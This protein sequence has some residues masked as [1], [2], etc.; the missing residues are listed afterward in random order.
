[1]KVIDLLK[2]ID[3]GE[4]VPLKIKV[5]GDIYKFD[6]LEYFYARGNGD[7]LL[8]LS[9]V[10]NTGELLDLP[11]EIIE[12]KENEI[13]IQSIEE[14]N[15]TCYDIKTMNN[16]EIEYYHNSTRTRLNE[17]IRAIKQLDNKINNI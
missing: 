6:T 16:D 9:T 14:L 11:I 2:M 7:D 1:M 17:V 4:E 13:D 15:D 3:E 8:E 12:D 10:F 5:D